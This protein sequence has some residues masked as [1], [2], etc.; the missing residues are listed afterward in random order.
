MGWGLKYYA[1]MFLRKRSRTVYS[2][3][4]LYFDFVL[5][6]SNVGRERYEYSIYF[7]NF[8]YFLYLVTLILFPVL[9]IVPVGGGEINVNFC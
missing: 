9:S 4:C 8:V 7:R 6:S 2:D 1:L 5:L 3:D